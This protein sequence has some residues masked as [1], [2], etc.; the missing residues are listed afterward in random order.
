MDRRHVFRVDCYPEPVVGQ[1][2]Q[3]AAEDVERLGLAL[4]TPVRLERRSSEP[5]VV[6]IVQFAPHHRT[7]PGQITLPPRLCEDMGLRHGNELEIALPRMFPVT[8]KHALREAVDGCWED[9][10]AVTLAQDVPLPRLAELVNISAGR[11]FDMFVVD[12]P[13][14]RQ[15]GD[16]VVRLTAFQ[17]CLLGVELGQ[18][19][20]FVAMDGLLPHPRA[21]NPLEKVLDRLLEI[22][23]GKR[24]LQLRC[25]RDMPVTE[26]SGYVRV[27]PEILRLLGA[28]EWDQVRLSYRDRAVT[29]RVLSLPDHG[30]GS[31]LNVIRIPSTLRRSL[32][33]DPGSVLKVERDRS[34]LLR[35]HLNL[36][37]IPIFGAILSVTQ[38][39]SV[40]NA[41]PRLIFPL[42]ILSAPLMLF[43]ALSRE[44]AK[45]R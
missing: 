20:I 16:Y 25:D 11:M 26:G 22:L 42:A 5:V 35:K 9:R 41:N 43:L 36:S 10:C 8:V 31:D 39:S 40:P 3:L 37:L 21:R 38:L 4:H 28:E 32:G 17:R 15:R 27:A 33:I 14:E 24:R 18:E 30:T 1:V 2:V 23:I 45:V 6:R 34:F 13:T 44:R 19:V 12:N 7:Q 29:C